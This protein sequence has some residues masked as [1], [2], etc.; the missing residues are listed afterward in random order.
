M[1]IIH[2]LMKEIKEV[3][4]QKMCNQRQLELKR[5]LTQQEVADIHNDATLSKK[6]NL[7]KVCLRFDAYDACTME[8]ICE[9][10]YSNVINNKK[11]PEGDLRIIRMSQ[12]TSPVSGGLD[13]LIFVEKVCRSEFICI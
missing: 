13:L 11:G 10:V 2:T 6:M 4:F 8:R 3:L 9:P 1:G 7:N 5:Q 12:Y